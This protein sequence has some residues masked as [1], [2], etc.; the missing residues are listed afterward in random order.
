MKVIQN[1]LYDIWYMLTERLLKE[2]GSPKEDFKE[3]G[4]RVWSVILECSHDFKDSPKAFAL[5]W[6]A[7]GNCNVTHKRLA[8][9]LTEEPDRWKWKWKKK[10]VTEYQVK[11]LLNDA[12]EKIFG[13][14]KIG[15]D[16]LISGLKNDG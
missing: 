12:R 3:D 6:A 4:R 8:E 9:L 2:R 11:W 15:V 5:F 14:A 16:I 1:N 13:K 7:L 10:P